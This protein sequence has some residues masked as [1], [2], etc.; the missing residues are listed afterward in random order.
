MKTILSIICLLHFSL[1]ELKAQKVFSVQY[2][3]QADVKGF[4][5]TSGVLP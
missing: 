5:V 3:N 4:V 2:A 1:H